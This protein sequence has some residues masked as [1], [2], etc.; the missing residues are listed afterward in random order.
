[1]STYVHVT[2]VCPPPQVTENRERLR[3]ARTPSDMAKVRQR[4][5][6]IQDH[7]GNTP[8]HYAV[9]LANCPGKGA[10]TEMIQWLLDNGADIN[11]QDSLPGKTTPLTMGMQ[12]LVPPPF[13]PHM[14]HPKAASIR[15]AVVELLSRGADPNLT[16]ERSVSPLIMPAGQPAGASESS[17]QQKR[18]AEIAPENRPA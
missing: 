17:R 1:M 18:V 6:D 7:A 3:G 8:L 16:L 14:R 10:R 2:P 4:M 11:K 13:A 12:K 9:Q 5:L 15:Q